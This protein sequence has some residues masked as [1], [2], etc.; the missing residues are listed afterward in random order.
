MDKQTILSHVDH[1][2]LDPAATWASIRQM[3]DDG[4]QYGVASVCIP[5]CYVEQAAGYLAGRLPVCTVVGFPHGNATTAAK[6]FEAADAVGQG[7]DE[8][9]MV[10]NQGWVKD[11]LLEQ[12]TAEIRAVKQAIGDC[13]LKVIVETCRLS[14]M[15]K[16]SL[17]RAVSAGGADFIKTST[18]FASA[19]ATLE[20]VELFAS[21]VDDGVLVKAAGGIR[22]FEQA[23][24]MLKR[25]AARLGASALVR[26]M[27]EEEE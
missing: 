14:E 7:A 11:G 24:A 20:D 23:E 26:L 22:T 10:I 9:D 19:G 27:K 18:G 17:C 1:T 8:I 3:C 15:E 6:C 2:E 4:L 16:V 13:V 12:V 5:P 25:G 21:M